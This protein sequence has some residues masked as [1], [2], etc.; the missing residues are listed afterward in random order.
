MKPEQLVG[1]SKKWNIVESNDFGFIEALN[2][3]G[4]TW[5]SFNVHRRLDKE[6]MANKQ[7]FY[8]SAYKLTTAKRYLTELTQ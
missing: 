5:R 1:K 7:V 8:K 6:K 4:G 2:M 3:V